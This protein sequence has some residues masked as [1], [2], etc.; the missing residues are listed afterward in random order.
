MTLEKRFNFLVFD[1]LI[2]KN[3]MAS[4]LRVFGK[5]RTI[6]YFGWGIKGMSSWVTTRFH[7]GFSQ[8]HGNIHPFLVVITSRISDAIS[9]QCRQKIIITIRLSCQVWRKK[10]ANKKNR[11]TLCDFLQLYN[12]SCYSYYS[13]LYNDVI[14]TMLNVSLEE[15]LFLLPLSWEKRRQNL[16]GLMFIR[17]KIHSNHK[18]QQLRT[19]P[20]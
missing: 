10:D 18:D 3:M 5:A 14:T 9:T 11:A 13:F 8:W 15:S 2:R 12:I 16:R 7:C 19:G 6:V 17:M 1:L 4:F 20:H